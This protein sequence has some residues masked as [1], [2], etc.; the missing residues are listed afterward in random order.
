MKKKSFTSF[1]RYTAYLLISCFVLLEIILRLAGYKAG[2][3]SPQWMNFTP[4]DSLEVYKSFYTN[5][6]GLFIADTAFFKTDYHINSAGFRDDAF[7]HDSSRTNILM[8]GDS[9]A[10]GSMAEP[11]DKCFAELIEPNGY[12]VFNTGIPGADPPQYLAIART[13]IPILKPDAV[14][15]MLYAGNDFIPTDRTPRPYQNIFHV[16]NAGWLSPYIGNTYTASPSDTYLH[17][18]NKYS[19]GKN[20]PLWKRV[21]ATSVTGTLLLQIPERIKEKRA[22]KSNTEIAKSYVTQIATLCQSSGIPFS[23]FLIPLHTDIHAGMAAEYQNIFHPYPV[24]IPAHISSADFIP[25][26]NGHLNNA[27]HKKYADLILETLE[28]AQESNSGSN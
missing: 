23:L 17:Y 12:N 13:Y 25:W 14:C 8:L 9:Y 6:E 15:L 5:S 21:V 1:I 10:W 18:L 2:I 20:A 3:I 16:T 24:H 27:G 11:I 28:K 4:V 26:P 22:W 19:I 7:V